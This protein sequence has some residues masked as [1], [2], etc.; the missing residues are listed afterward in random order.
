MRVN[1]TGGGLKSGSERESA[2]AEAEAEADD[3]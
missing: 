3:V 2:E 1:E